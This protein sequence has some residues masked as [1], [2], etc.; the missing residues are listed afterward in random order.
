MIRLLVLIQVSVPLA[1]FF[2]TRIRIESG[3]RRS[4]WNFPA[5]IITDIPLSIRIDKILRWNIEEGQSIRKFLPIL[6][7]VEAIECL[8][9]PSSLIN[10]PA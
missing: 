9:G 1:F 3:H 8:H 7:S 6:G 5:Q 4:Q 2:P 10:R